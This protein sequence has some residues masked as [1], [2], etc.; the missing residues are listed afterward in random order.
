MRRA[1]GEV[2]SEMVRFGRLLYE[3]RLVTGLSG[4][5]SA[6]VDENT[7]LISPSGRCKGD[8]S[9]DEL[10]RMSIKEGKVMS[11]GEPSMETPFHLAF[12]R[13]RED[14]GGVVHAH[15]L[16]CTLLACSGTTVR[17][18]L[19]PEGLIYLGEV[20]FIPYSMPGTEGLMENIRSAM[21]GRHSFLLENHG[22]VTVGKDLAEAYYRMETL[23]FLAQLQVLSQISGGTKALSPSQVQE[24]LVL[25][26]KD[27]QVYR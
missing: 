2:R 19:T 7:L 3:K 9:T 25:M 20:A 13:E 16:F 8:L 17:T 27:G 23:E 14:I 21:K 24:L 12:Y 1:E 11:G 4:N 6:R 22:A 10:V 5:I 18:D 15:P 26:K